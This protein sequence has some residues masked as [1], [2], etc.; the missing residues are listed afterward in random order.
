MAQATHPMDGAIRT[1]EGLSRFRAIL[2]FSETNWGMSRDSKQRN[3][4]QIPSVS[5]LKSCR[6]FASGPLVTT[7]PIDGKLLG[8]SPSSLFATE[9]VDI[10]HKLHGVVD[11]LVHGFEADLIEVKR[12]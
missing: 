11:R 7:Y 2:P 12:D 1:N 5:A 8:I 3:D 10:K 6:N 9:L 4:L